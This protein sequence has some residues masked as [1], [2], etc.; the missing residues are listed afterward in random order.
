MINMIDHFADVKNT[1]A[2]WWRFLL[3]TLPVIGLVLFSS[4]FFLQSEERIHLESVRLET[5]HHI[6]SQGKHSNS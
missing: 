3:L 2:L 4:Y 1:R 5:A 6:E